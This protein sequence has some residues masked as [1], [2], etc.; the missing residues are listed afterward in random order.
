MVGTNTPKLYAPALRLHDAALEELGLALWH[1][2]RLK[3]QWRKLY[4]TRKLAQTAEESSR[5]LSTQI[6]D[7]EEICRRMTPNRTSSGRPDSAAQVGSQDPQPTPDA[8]GRNGE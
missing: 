1:P 4:S 3:L 8:A 6:R 7:M 5:K 2:V